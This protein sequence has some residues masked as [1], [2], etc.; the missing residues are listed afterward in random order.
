MGYRF[1]FNHK[2]P[3]SKRKCNKLHLVRL[4]EEVSD[5][6]ANT[7]NESIRVT[8][9]IEAQYKDIDLANTLW[10]K[11]KQTNKKTMRHSVLTT[12]LKFITSTLRQLSQRLLGLLVTE[13]RLR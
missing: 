7:M 2:S 5:S 4:V 13:K 12:D 3:N 8:N 9:H 11:K 10:G 6:L 1:F